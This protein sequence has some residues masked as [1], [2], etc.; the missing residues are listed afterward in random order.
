[1]SSTTP[2]LD[3]LDDNSRLDDRNDHPGLD[4]WDD[5]ASGFLDRRLARCECRPRFVGARFHR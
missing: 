3:H 4:H 2:Q 1:M 5:D